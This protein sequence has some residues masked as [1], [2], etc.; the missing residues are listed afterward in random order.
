MRD[1][2]VSPY[3]KRQMSMFITRLG[4]SSPLFIH[5]LHL[6]GVLLGS[7]PVLISFIVAE[8]RPGPIV[9]AFLALVIF[10]FAATRSKIEQPAGVP[11]ALVALLRFGVVILIAVMAF[12]GTFAAGVVGSALAP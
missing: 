5:L 3:D 6:G 2:T 12:I 8:G 10:M 9:A 11:S 7:L 1:T 4:P